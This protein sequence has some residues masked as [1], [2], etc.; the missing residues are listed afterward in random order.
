MS[1]KDG[2]RNKG[3][4]LQWRKLGLHIKPF[5]Q[6]GEQIIG[7]CSLG[8]WR[9]PHHEKY[10]ADKCAVNGIRIVHLGFKAVGGPS[11]SVSL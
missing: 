8:R 1:A 7:V 4:K 3:L 2:T 10:S 6:Q 9:N 5:Y 11:R